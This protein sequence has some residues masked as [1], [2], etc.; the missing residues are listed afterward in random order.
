MLRSNLLERFRG[1]ETF[2]A[3]GSLEQ[4]SAGNVPA[5]SYY[6]QALDL[7]DQELFAEAI[8]SLKKA[9]AERP[10]FAEAHCEM[11]RAYSRLGRFEDAIKAYSS[12]LKANPNCVDAYN[13]L[14]ATYDLAGQSIE[15]IKICMKAMRLDPR[16]TEVRNTLGIAY[17]NIGSYAEAVKAHQQVIKIKPDD[18]TAH[19]CLGVIYIDLQDKEAAL[20]EQK[21]LEDCGHSEVASQLLDEIHWQF[22]GRPSTPLHDSPPAVNA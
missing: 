1:K 3:G 19:Y 7:I 6:A 11:G 22:S 13:Q 8:H 20:G 12:A 2:V 18:V 4:Q 21:T 16:A 15:A 5:H 10:E 14:A 9:I 17:F